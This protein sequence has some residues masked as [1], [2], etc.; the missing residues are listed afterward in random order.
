M[1]VI[2]NRANFV[3]EFFILIKIFMEEIF[4][5]YRIKTEWT[6]ES[7]DGRLQKNEDRRVGLCGEL[8]GC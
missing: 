2:L 1:Y 7:S 6:K 4:N 3:Y 5:Y 8:H